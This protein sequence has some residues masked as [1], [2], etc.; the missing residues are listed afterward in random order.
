MMTR[1]LLLFLAAGHAWGADGLVVC[2]GEEVFRIDPA[3]T[4]EKRWSW[5]ARDSAEIPEELKGAFATTDDCKPVDG[6]KRLLVSSSAGGCA[7]LELPSGK[8]VWWARVANAHTIEALPGGRIAVAASVGAKGNKVVF[9]DAG[10]IG[11]PIAEFPLPSAHGLV[12]DGK[13]DVLWAMGYEELVSCE[14][15]P[16]DG[17]LAPRITGRF[18]LPDKDGH[19]LRAVPESPELVLS[20]D[21]GVWR[22]DRETKTFRADPDLKDRAM[23]K[24]TDTQPDTGR[25]AFTQADGGN[26]W[27]DT[28]R[29]LN[30][31]GEM[32]MDGER[33]YKVRWIRVEE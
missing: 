28:V 21:K 11:E 19:D 10:K 29:F 7:L 9:F 6:G 32:K 16:K 5:R 31:E 26:W 22:F 12:W 15:G 27:T 33:I 25:R 4:A 1:L 13:R 30:P 3:K 8:A 2:G 14:L 20:T 18:P 17:K 24:C 23:V